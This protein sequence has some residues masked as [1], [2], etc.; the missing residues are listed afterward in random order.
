[1]KIGLLMLRL[2]NLPDDFMWINRL[3]KLPP[4]ALILSEFATTFLAAKDYGS[5]MEPID[6]VRTERLDIEGYH[7]VATVDTQYNLD[8]FPWVPVGNSEGARRNGQ[9]VSEPRRC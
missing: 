7:A 5:W 3:N 1:M 4:E 8:F 9:E 6:M 2:T